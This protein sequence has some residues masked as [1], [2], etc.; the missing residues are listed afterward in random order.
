MVDSG[1]KVCSVSYLNAKGN[2]PVIAAAPELLDCLV[3]I[4]DSIDSNSGSPHF[5]AEQHD[6]FESVIAKAKGEQ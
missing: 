4:C 5:T 1:D 3:A 2:A 6:Y